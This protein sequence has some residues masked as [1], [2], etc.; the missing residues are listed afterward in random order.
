MFAID[1]SVSCC[2][3]GYGVSVVEAHHALS[4]VLHVPH[5]CRPRHSAATPLKQPHTPGSTLKGDT[6]ADGTA[7]TVS[8]AG[9]AAAA[10]ASATQIAETSLQQCGITQEQIA[11]IARI[12]RAAAAATSPGITSSTLESSTA[13]A[14][15]AGGG[16]SCP[17]LFVAPELLQIDNPA[18]LD[19]MV[20]GL[21]VG[22]VQSG[23]AVL[24]AAVDVSLQFQLLLHSLCDALA[25]H[26]CFTAAVRWWCPPT[27]RSRLWT[28]E[29]VV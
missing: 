27:G 29:M 17:F 5:T 4:C 12:P 13:A 21:K 3:H 1:D 9:P 11:G 14:G 2:R 28:F 15:A 26:Q 7:A 23:C 19:C 20:R 8:S 24:S 25:R 22:R 18:A 10:A 6:L 16:A